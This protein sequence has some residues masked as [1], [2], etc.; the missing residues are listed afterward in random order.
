MAIKGVDLLPPVVSKDEALK[1]YKKVAQVKPLIGTLNAELEH[2]LVS[3]S[4]IQIFSLKES[5]ES[6]RIEGTQVTFTDIIEQATK[7]QKSSEVIAVENYQKALSKGIEAIERDEP[8]STRLILELHRTLMANQTRGTTSASGEF[9]KTQNFL[10][11]TKNIED[12]VYIPVA[13]NE[14]P[15]YMTNWEYYLNSASHSSFVKEINEETEFVLDENS[16]TL[17]KTAIAHAQFE[18][19]H[20][21]LDGNGR[22]GRIIIVLSTMQDRLIN[23]PVFFVSEELEKERLRYY[24]RLNATRGDNPN[25]FSWIAFFLDSC[26]RMALNMLQKLE[27]INELANSGLNQIERKGKTPKVWLYTFMKPFVTTNE[28]AEFFKIST[29]AARTSLNYLVDIGLL[30]P[31]SSKNRNKVYVNYDLLRVLNE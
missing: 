23:R 27:S 16:D 17:I 5:V 11:P 24:N 1:L 7:E 14:I 19:I 4:L 10:G 22:M 6:T 28:T 8:I 12:A 26:E 30:E 29:T 31:D 3:D 13:A 18:S 2:S 20:P 21:F 9:R 15:H 25:W